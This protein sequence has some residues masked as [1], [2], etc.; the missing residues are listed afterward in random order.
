MIRPRQKR[1]QGT[2]VSMQGSKH[3]MACIPCQDSSDLFTDRSSC[4]LFVA[5]GAGSAPHSHFASQAAV[6]RAKGYYQEQIAITRPKDESAWRLLLSAC[7]VKAREAIGD[8]V[9]DERP[10]PTL[11]TTFLMM[12]L[13]AYNAVTVHIGDG[14]GFVV[15]QENTF[16]LL[17]SPENGEYI[18]QTYFLTDRDWE[19]HLHVTYQ[20]GHFHAGLA[21]S[22]GLQCIALHHGTPFTGFANGIVTQLREIRPKKRQVALQQYLSQHIIGKRTDDDVSLV[23]AWR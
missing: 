11:R 12:V 4:A 1:W 18:N 6:E 22:D 13:N 9:T 20:P 3:V 17:A 5:D 8:L 23:V 15:D 19:E 10:L 7:A 14:A 16:T 2:A 21:F